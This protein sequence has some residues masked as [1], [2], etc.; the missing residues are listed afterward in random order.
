MMLSLAVVGGFCFSS[1]LESNYMNHV[2]MT[3]SWFGCA[4]SRIVGNVLVNGVV[5][6]MSSHV[7]RRLLFL[8]HRQSWSDPWDC[9]SSCLKNCKQAWTKMPSTLSRRFC[10][11]NRW[12][13]CSC[14]PFKTKTGTL[15]ETAEIHQYVSCRTCRSQFMEATIKLWAACHSLLRGSHADVS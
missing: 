9:L 5:P 11:S 4:S 10:K 7:A 14:C 3:T 13:R 15:M 6:E 1:A 8:P 2:C 12:T